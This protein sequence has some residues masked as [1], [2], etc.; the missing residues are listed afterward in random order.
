MLLFLLTLPLFA[1]NSNATYLKKNDRPI[2]IT[3][4]IQ[5][6]KADSFAQKILDDREALSKADLDLAKSKYFYPDLNMTI[7]VSNHNLLKN[8]A[9]SQNFKIGL[10]KYTIFNWGKDKRAYLSAIKEYE[11]QKAL[12]DQEGHTLRYQGLGLYFKIIAA[13]QKLSAYDQKIGHAS[14][15]YR[16]NRERRGQGNVSDVDYYRTRDKFLEAQSDQRNAQIELYHL[17]EELSKMLNE[18]ENDINYI[19]ESNIGVTPLTLDLESYYEIAKINNKNIMAMDAAVA[20]LTNDYESTL[21][22]SL[23]LPKID[24]GLAFYRWSGGP[25]NNEYFDKPKL[26]VAINATWQLFGGKGFFN[27][28]VN[29][30]ISLNRKVVQH[31]LNDYQLAIKRA[32]QQ[33]MTKITGHQDNI[34]LQDSKGLNSKTYFD[35]ALRDYVKGQLDLNTLIVAR[36]GMRED[37]IDITDSHLEQILLKMQLAELLGL[38]NLPGDPFENLAIK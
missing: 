25:S 13:H 22:D 34:D 5:K 1:Q 24:L 33:L 21:M 15:L 31:Q 28:K 38:S 8:D 9:P 36:D 26:E 11:T 14:Y 35:T 18:Q 12:I 17:S 7:E 37:R 6:I 10:E 23:F 27:S 3:E 32:I 2:T 29:N 30:Q 19:T 4:V 20:K 16:F